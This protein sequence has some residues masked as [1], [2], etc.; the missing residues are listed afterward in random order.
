ML[1]TIPNEND[2]ISESTRP[3]ETQLQQTTQTTRRPTK[4]HPPKQITF[5]PSA[6]ESHHGILQDPRH[7][8]RQRNPLATIPSTP[9]LHATHRIENDEIHRK[10]RHSKRN[11][12]TNRDR[13]EYV[14][15]FWQ[16][17]LY[18]RK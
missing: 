5:T 14:C 9:F 11:L 17:N 1:E 7:P 4:A 8:T 3:N 13:F 12:P 16:K 18:E 2:T 10:S 6:T 15:E